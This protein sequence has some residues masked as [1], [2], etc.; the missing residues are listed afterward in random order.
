MLLGDVSDLGGTVTGCSSLRLGGAQPAE[1]VR[2]RGEGGEGRKGGETEGGPYVATLLWQ[3]SACLVPVVGAPCSVTLY[4]RIGGC[5]LTKRIML[6]ERHV[7]PREMWLR[8]GH[9]TAALLVPC[10]QLVLEI[11]PCCCK[12][13]QQLHGIWG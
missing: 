6:V 10:Q 13:Q 3:Q 5:P 12:L 9:L 2:D 1:G 11:G 4:I 8:L 7:V